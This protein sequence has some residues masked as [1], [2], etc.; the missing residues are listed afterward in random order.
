MG[1]TAETPTRKGK[2]KSG[3]SDLAFG[4]LISGFY[5]GMGFYESLF[6]PTAVPRY[7][8]G[9]RDN[10]V[11]DFTDFMG[12]VSGFAGYAAGLGNWTKLIIDNPENPLSYIPVVTNLISGAAQIGY[13]R[14]KKAGRIRQ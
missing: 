9:I 10:G 14:G 1:I 13:A 3:L 6:N 12:Y 8:R 7:I 11:K 5:L 2:I 4:T